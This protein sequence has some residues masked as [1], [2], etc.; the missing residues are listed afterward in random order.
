MAD[1][2]EPHRHVH[3]RQAGDASRPLILL[4]GKEAWREGFDDLLGTQQKRHFRVVK[5]QIY[6]DAWYIGKLIQTSRPNITDTIRCCFS[7]EICF[8]GFFMF[9]K[10]RLV[11]FL[12]IELLFVSWFC[13]PSWSWLRRLSRV[14]P[15]WIFHGNHRESFKHFKADSPDSAFGA[16]IKLPDTSL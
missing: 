1:G 11:T 14:L 13:E 3:A 16:S 4:L 7:L 10:I 9:G 6:V 15:T 2:S 8:V 5:W 12:S